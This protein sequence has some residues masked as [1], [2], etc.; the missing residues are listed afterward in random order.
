M[1]KMVRS[2][3]IAAAVAASLPAAAQYGPEYSP[4]YIGAGIGRGNLNVSGTDLTGIN[5]A[6]VDDTSNTYS[7]RL[8]WRFSRYMALELGYY[9]LGKFQ[10]AGRQIGAGLDTSGEAKAKSVGISFVGIIP[11]ESLD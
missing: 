8:G 10:F 3:L 9:D 2:A 6:S 4:W 5:N 11:I 7:A 1:N